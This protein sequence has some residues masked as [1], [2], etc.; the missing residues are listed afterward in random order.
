MRL[1]IFFVCVRDLSKLKDL[2]TI[3]QH[4]SLFNKEKG[5]R[6]PHAPTHDNGMDATRG[7]YWLFDWWLNYILQIHG[8]MHGCI[9]I[10]Q[11]LLYNQF[12]SSMYGCKRNKLMFPSNFATSVFSAAWMRMKRLASQNRNLVDAGAYPYEK[13]IKQIIFLV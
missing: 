6:S 1:T 3:L 13:N 7:P 8:T 5:G 9:Y 2:Q 11:T 4:V 10:L 12:G